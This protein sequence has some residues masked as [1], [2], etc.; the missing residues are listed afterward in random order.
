LTSRPRHGG[1][2]DQVDSPTEGSDTSMRLEGAQCCEF[3]LELGDPVII[4][5]DDA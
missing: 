1:T 5:I 3:A 4:G 2:P